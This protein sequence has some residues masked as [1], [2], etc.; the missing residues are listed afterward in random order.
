MKKIV[1]I[2]SIFLIV[3]LFAGL[4]C[5]CAE[6][7]SPP[8]G[9]RVAMISS[10]SNITDGGFNQI[11]YETSKAFCEKYYVPFR[12]YH[13]V[14][15]TPDTIMTMIDA[16]INDD[17]NFLIM[18]G[19]QFAR[20]VRQAAAVDKDVLFVL[21]DVAP[22]DFGKDYELPKNIFCFT[23]RE[24]MAAFM[25]GYAAVRDGYRHLGF[26]GGVAV[27]AVV[28][29]GYGFIQ[30][31][32]AAAKELG[33]DVT[34]EYVYG[35]QFYGDADITAYMDNWYQNKN[36]EVVFSCG[37]S[38]WT[39]VASAAKRVGGKM[40]G[41]DI[42][43]KA[44]INAYTGQNTTL[45]SAIKRLDVVTQKV[46]KDTLDGHW[47]AWGGNYFELGT[48]VPG[49]PDATFV[50]LTPESWGFTTYSVD[51][52]KMLLKKLQSGE[53]EVSVDTTKEPA[54]SITVNYLG[55]IK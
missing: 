34:V 29:F 11:S 31:A 26:L 39:S 16:A 19:T 51:D 12:H 25:A 35:N 44:E 43:Q 20:S 9:L 5:G 21:S 24:D 4:L 15:D 55:S 33:A 10:Q 36:V 38:I 52:Y 6:H 30:G 46:L 28:R 37:A 18:N 27:P 53:P 49:Q 2:S 47:D 50:A 8:E 54:V 1:Q 45:T 23:F 13:C 3:S 42:D 41:V 14:D 22:A 48:T 40:I 7:V 32:D 17:Y